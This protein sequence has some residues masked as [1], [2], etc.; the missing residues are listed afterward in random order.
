MLDV[1]FTEEFNPREFGLIPN[2]FGERL[3]A[4]NQW[5]LDGSWL[6]RETAAEVWS[7]LG[8]ERVGDFLRWIEYY[9]LE[10]RR[11]PKSFRGYDPTHESPS[12]LPQIVLNSV[13]ICRR[14]L[15]PA[16]PLSTTSDEWH[17][18]GVASRHEDPRTGHPFYCLTLGDAYDSIRMSAGLVSPGEHFLTLAANGQNLTINDEHLTRHFYNFLGDVCNYLVQDDQRAILRMYGSHEFLVP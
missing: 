6:P 1:A 14:S 16:D 5:E 3:R 7:E 11:E 13:R 4:R 10:L 2:Q 12:G 18:V 17:T 8:I 9:A 15:S